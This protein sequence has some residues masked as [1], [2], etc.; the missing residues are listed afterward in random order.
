MARKHWHAHSLLVTVLNWKQAHVHQQVSGLTSGGTCVWCTCVWCTCESCVWRNTV[1][2]RKEREDKTTFA[3]CSGHPSTARFLYLQTESLHP[4]EDHCLFL[5]PHCPWNP[6][7]YFLF[8]GVRLSWVP[9]RSRTV[10]HLSFVLAYLTYRDAG[11]FH[12]CTNAWEPFLFC[13]VDYYPCTAIPHFEHLPV[14]CRWTLGLSL[15]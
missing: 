3:S 14:T 1:Q 15:S 13:N 4:L 5:P 10:Q 12:P 6:P 8:L 7:L 11:K 2:P 9:R